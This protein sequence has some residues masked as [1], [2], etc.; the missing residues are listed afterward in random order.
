MQHDR[1]AVWPLNDK[2][3]GCLMVQREAGGETE[4]RYG[5]I[6]KIL[7]FIRDRRIEPFERLP[8]ERDFAEKF[9]TSRSAI[10]EALAA[11]EVMRVIVRRPNSGIYLRGL[12]ERSIET[13]VVQ[14]ETGMPFSRREISDVFEVRLMLEVQAAK[15]ASQRR[16]DEDLSRMH[17]V[18]EKTGVLI[19]RHE[20]IEAEDEAF[21]LA[22]FASTKNE[23]LCQTVAS[24]YEFSRPRR[25][26]YFS[27]HERG[28]RSYADHR[29]ILSAIEDGNA[30]SAEIS[31]T[32][33]LSK[34][35]EAWAKLL[36]ETRD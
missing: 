11:L 28:A 7:T 32:A 30:E 14:A 27:D 36:V 25:R 34:A 24:F 22:I 1:T 26:I 6:A 16:T 13:L 5:S 20:T 4:P 12:E 2:G 17:D 18:L 9:S 21:H 8:S 33:H 29:A 15:L 10:R 19:E 31:I 35:I 3:Q 23:V